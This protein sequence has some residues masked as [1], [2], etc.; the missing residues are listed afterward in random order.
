MTAT[1][2]STTAPADLLFVFAGADERKRFA[3]DSWRT[4]CASALVMSVA[5]FEWRRAPLLGLPG[6]GGLV[7]L[8][9]AT[10]P[11]ERLFVL[12]VEGVTVVARRVP[13]GRWGTWSEA[14]AIAALVRERKAKSLLICTSGYHLPR[15]LLAVRRALASG[16]VVDCAAAGIAAPESHGSPLAAS[17][18]WR[19]PRAWAPLLRERFKWLVYALG[20]PMAFESPPSAP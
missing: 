5:R 14:L 9:E 8:V 18:S 1:G 20:I 15:A 12:I 7:G 3:I 13:K 11:R 17:R 4:G 19:S 2:R 10:P 16:G 6:D